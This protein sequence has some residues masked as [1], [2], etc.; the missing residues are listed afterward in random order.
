MH[1]ADEIDLVASVA[2]LGLDHPELDNDDNLRAVCRP[3]HRV[4]S[5]AQRDAA[6]KTSAARRAARRHLPKGKHPGE[7]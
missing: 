3:C 6:I 2:E 1:Y 5:D 7:L 4:R